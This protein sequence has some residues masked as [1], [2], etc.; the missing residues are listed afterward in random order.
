ML[1]KKTYNIIMEIG[2]QIPVHPYRIII[3]IIIIVTIIT[4]III[5]II[6]IIG[7]FA[8]GKTSSLI[9]LR[10]LQPDIDKINFRL[11]NEKVQS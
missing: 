8:S 3:I 5:I 4:M 2:P 7:S 11:T 9:N 1:Q 6:I 10:S